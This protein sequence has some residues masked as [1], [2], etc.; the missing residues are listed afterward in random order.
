MKAGPLKYRLSLLKPVV[1]ANGYGEEVVTYVETRTVHAGRT[2]MSGSWGVTVG[3]KFPDYNTE[4]DIR[5]EHEVEENW[6]VKEL[7]G[8][9]YTVKNIIPNPDR[10]MKTLVCERVNE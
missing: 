2:K 5:E 8:Y 6:R 4:W 1:V 10:Q 9:L 7:A 3:E